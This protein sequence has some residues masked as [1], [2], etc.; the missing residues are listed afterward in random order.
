MIRA[1]GH[2]R[3]GALRIGAQLPGLCVVI[4]A[5]SFIT[6]TAIAGAEQPGAGTSIPSASAYERLL[7]AALSGGADDPFERIGRAAEARLDAACRPPRPP[8]D[9]CFARHLQPMPERIAVLHSGPS[10][11]SAPVAYVMAVPFVVP[12]EF[13]SFS[14]RLDV[15]PV[16]QPGG[17]EP[18]IADVGD[19]GYGVHIDG[20]VRLVGDWVQLLYPPAVAGAFL[21]LQ[22]PGLVVDVSSFEENILEIADVPGLADGSYFIVGVTPERVELRLEVDSDMACGEPVE[23]VIALPPVVAA[24][25]SQFFDSN[26]RPRFRTKYTKG[27]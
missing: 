6:L 11:S 4:G 22:G 24:S 3:I 18:W 17:S 1:L 27:C 26:G 12:G 15:Q 7:I 16:A 13:E 20:Q 21:Q 5:A 9:R 10:E 19:W 2:W 25:P 8:G 23:P 14:I